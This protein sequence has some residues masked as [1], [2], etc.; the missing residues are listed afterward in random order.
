M[1]LQAGPYRDMANFLGIRNV[2]LGAAAPL[3]SA[4]S[5]VP[6]ESQIRVPDAPK[7]GDYIALH[8]ERP[9]TDVMGVRTAPGD[10]GPSATALGY[11]EDFRAGLTGD[12]E[13][14]DFTVENS[15][16]GFA[17]AALSL[18][19]LE[20]LRDLGL[21]AFLVRRGQTAPLVAGEPAMLAMEGRSTH[22]S[23]VVTPHSDFAGRLRGNFSI[24]QN[25]PNPVRTHTTFRFT[26]PQTWDAA[27]RREAKTYRLR[28]NLYDYSGRLVARVADGTFKPGSHTLIWKP[29]AANGGGL[30]KGAYV[31][32]MEVPG[33]AKSLK[34]LLK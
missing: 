11:A 8:F 3:A 31:Y 34:L 13:W 2:T 23:I 12:E 9:G 28:L 26:L 16:S 27:G 5:A 19:G 30:A 29:Q 4:A 17:A 14:W 10:A 20:N 6:A 1:S 15:G 25:F 32:R 22:Y 21:H 18:P 7:F 33:F 24:S